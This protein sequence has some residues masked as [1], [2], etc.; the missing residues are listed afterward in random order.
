M[1]HLLITGGAGFIGSHTALV[2]LQAGHSL[3]VLDNFAN[4]SPEALR[5]VAELAGLS[6]DAAAPSERL[7]VIAVTFATRT[8]STAPWP[9][10]PPA[11]AP[12]TG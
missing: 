5:R 6:D 9:P 11:A 10:R 2:L 3:V 4:S 12:S 1:A 7:Q 8:I